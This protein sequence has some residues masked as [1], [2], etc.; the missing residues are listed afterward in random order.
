[1]KVRREVLKLALEVAKESY[2]NEFVAL[3]TGKRGVIE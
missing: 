1:M 3:L 2:P